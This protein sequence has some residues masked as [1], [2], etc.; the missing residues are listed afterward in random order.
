MIFKF[1]H[2]SPPSSVGFVASEI[3]I[4]DVT[5]KE[6]FDPEVEIYKEIVTLP[7]KVFE[8]KANHLNFVDILINKGVSLILNKDLAYEIEEQERDYKYFSQSDNLKWVPYRIEDFKAKGFT[9]IEYRK[10]TAFYLY[11]GIE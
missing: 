3:I 2:R 11:Y 10:L 7:Y 8:T 6:I 1:D 4:K 9:L 5:T